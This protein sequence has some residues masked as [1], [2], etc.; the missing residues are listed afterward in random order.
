MPSAVETP[1]TRAER[2]EKY[3]LLDALDMFVQNLQH[4]WGSSSYQGIFH[5]L[6]PEDGPTYDDAHEG[7][8]SALFEELWPSPP[9]VNLDH[10]P[11]FAAA[12]VRACLLTSRMFAAVAAN[13]GE[14]WKVSDYFAGLADKGLRDI[15][16]GGDDVDH[17]KKCDV[18]VCYA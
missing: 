13:G 4:T 18:C 7:F 15:E 3:V 12:S 14:C 11:E 1:T 5:D 2:V 17:I 8:S 9:N 6:I 10:N 16:K